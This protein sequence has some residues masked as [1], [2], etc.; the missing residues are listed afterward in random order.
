V[1]SLK[2]FLSA[3]VLA[4]DESDL[5]TNKLTVLLK[6]GQ[7]MRVFD[8]A[9]QSQPFIVVQIDD[10]ESLSA[11]D[12][13]ALEIIVE[14]PE[15]VVVIDRA[16]QVRG[17]VEPHR[18]KDLWIAASATIK[19]GEFGGK[20]VSPQGDIVV[21]V[22]YYGCR[23][24]PEAGRFVLHQVGAPIPRCPQCGEPMVELYKKSNR[25][26]SK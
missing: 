14:Q 22:S 7:P 25:T 24:H 9:K 16:E 6:D 15:W 17:I 3:W 26:K 2:A 23:R 8:R 10:P 21:S 13:A 5:R 12:I 11:T 1:N 20:I 19:R 4:N 18:T